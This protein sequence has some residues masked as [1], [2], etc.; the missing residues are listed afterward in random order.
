MNKP[1]AVFVTY[2]ETVV[3]PQTIYQNENKNQL[4]PD[5]HVHLKKD[6]TKTE[7]SAASCQSSNT[8]YKRKKRK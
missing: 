1:D 5:A 2:E 6:A 3:V 4:I 7:D 8:M